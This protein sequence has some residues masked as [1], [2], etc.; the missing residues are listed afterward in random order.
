MNKMRTILF[1]DINGS[2]FDPKLD[3]EKYYNLKTNRFV[4]AVPRDPNFTYSLF[5]K[6]TGTSEMI[7]RFNSINGINTKLSFEVGDVREKVSN[8]IIEGLY[9]D[10]NENPALMNIPN[11]KDV[12][13]YKSILL[14]ENIEEKLTV[15]HVFLENKSSEFIADI[16]NFYQSKRHYFT[17]SYAFENKIINSLVKLININDKIFYV[18]VGYKFSS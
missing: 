9:N 15:K 5:P 14:L 8:N 12:S 13:L 4:K 2:F 11:K 10:F 3:V 6:I 17:I 7:K 1:S 18:E 16:N